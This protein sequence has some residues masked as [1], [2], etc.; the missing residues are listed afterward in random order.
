MPRCTWTL[1]NIKVVFS[2]NRRK[3]NGFVVNIEEEFS[4]ITNY[5]SWHDNI[6]LSFMEHLDI[7]S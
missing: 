6:F 1:H 2:E 5:S 7:I 3:Q 4:K